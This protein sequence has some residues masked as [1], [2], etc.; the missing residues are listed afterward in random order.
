M[1]TPF[2]VSEVTLKRID[3]GFVVKWD[4]ESPWVTANH[5]YYTEDLLDAFA[6]QEEVL[7][8]KQD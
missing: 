4:E 6:K 7:K 2:A 1:D 3:N 8:R 5:E